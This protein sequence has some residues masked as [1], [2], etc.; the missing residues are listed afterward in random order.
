MKRKVVN[1]KSGIYIFVKLLMI[2]VIAALVYYSINTL[3]D[4]PISRI[5]YIGRKVHISRSVEADSS[6]S[7]SSDKL[8]SSYAILVR[9]MDN[10]VL[11]QKIVKKKSTQLL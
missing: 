3:L 10:T 1:K 7:I 8:N 2:V 6:V 11:M 5:K 4:H 9:L